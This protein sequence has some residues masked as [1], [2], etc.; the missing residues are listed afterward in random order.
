VGVGAE[1]KNVLQRPTIAARAIAGTALASLLPLRVSYLPASERLAQVQTAAAANP[2][3]PVEGMLQALQLAEPE[4]HQRLDAAFQSAFHQHLRLDQSQRVALTLRVAESFPAV[5]GHAFAEAAAL[6]QV[7]PLE[8]QGAS[9][10]AYATVVLGLLL[11]RGRVVLIDQPE[12]FLPPAT[13]HHLG[14][15]IASHIAELQCQVVLTTNQPALLRGLLDGPADVTVVRLTRQGS[16]THLQSVTPEL[17][18]MLAR[19]PLLASQAAVDACFGDLVVLTPDSTDALLYEAVAMRAG[20][21]QGVKFLHAYGETHLAPMAR[22]LR[23][24]G[25]AVSVITSFLALRTEHG[26]RELVEAVRSE[27]PPRPWLAT[28]ERFASVMDRAV[29]PASRAASAQELEVFLDQLKQG[30]ARQ[31]PPPDQAGETG[32]APTGW[33]RLA[34][35]KLDRVPPELRTWVEELMEDLKHCGIFIAQRGGALD[36]FSAADLGPDHSAWL[37]RAIKLLHEGQVPVEMQA[38]V[39]EVLAFGRASRGL[40]PSAAAV[41]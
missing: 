36:W 29:D 12:L 6:S 8:S 28:R 39:T 10:Q 5:Q 35:D 40:S 19:H 24:A 7:P 22:V 32:S 23:Q 41:R 11:S 38:L 4:T 37:M 3:Q 17:G 1:L 31:A 2:L 34:M 26:F 15:W 33:D 25:L 18:R 9:W 16:A 14:R 13:A 27:P 21:A 30:P 20:L